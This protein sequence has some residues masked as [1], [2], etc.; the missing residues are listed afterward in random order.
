MPQWSH[1]IL[2]NLKPATLPGNVSQFRNLPFA[3]AGRFE[4][5]VLKTGKLSETVYDATE[6]G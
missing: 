5:P 4:D 1:P 6:I 3:T 2:G